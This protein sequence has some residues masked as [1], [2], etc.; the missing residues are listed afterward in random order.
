MRLNAARWAVVAASVSYFVAALADAGPIA[1]LPLWCAM[2]ASVAVMTHGRYPFWRFRRAR[3]RLGL[4]AT[5]AGLTA[6]VALLYLLGGLFG[7]IILLPP[8]DNG[9][10]AILGI[11]A[12]MMGVGAGLAGIALRHAWRYRAKS[13][14]QGKTYGTCRTL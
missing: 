4:M 12:W 14:R 3:Y 11:V 8:A 7:L 1:M 6:S 2:S 5:R 13:S 10:K 9:D